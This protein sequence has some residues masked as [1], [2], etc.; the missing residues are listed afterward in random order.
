MRKQIS[1]RWRWRYTGE[2]LLTYI[3]LPGLAL[4]IFDMCDRIKTMAIIISHRRM[5]LATVYSILY[6]VNVH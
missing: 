5:F 2:L 6:S 4:A 3:Q 1:G